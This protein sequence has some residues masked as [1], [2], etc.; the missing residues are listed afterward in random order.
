M[1]YNTVASRLEGFLFHLTGKVYQ[2]VNTEYKVFDITCEGEIA[3]LDIRCNDL[4]HAFIMGLTDLKEFPDSFV[5]LTEGCYPLF[6]DAE[7][8]RFKQVLSSIPYDDDK[9]LLV[10]L[11]EE[12]DQADDTRQVRYIANPSDIWVDL[13]A[14]CTGRWWQ[15]QED[16]KTTE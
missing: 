16:L 12:W 15:F 14:H 5:K 13:I 2:V 6:K 1:T 8:L 7:L 11:S 3:T 10:M 4:A 9:E